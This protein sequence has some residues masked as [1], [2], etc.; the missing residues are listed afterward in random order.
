M[1]HGSC[2]YCPQCNELHDDCVCYVD[3]EGAFDLL[4]KENH[5]LLEEIGR[6]RQTIRDLQEQLRVL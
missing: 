1:A 6:L 3:F 2:C 4:T 5:E